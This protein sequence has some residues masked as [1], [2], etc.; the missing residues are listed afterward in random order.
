MKD[1]TRKERKASQKKR[2]LKYKESNK[3]NVSVIEKG[4]I[5]KIRYFYFQE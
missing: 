5:L 4:I 3:G 2:K 1:R